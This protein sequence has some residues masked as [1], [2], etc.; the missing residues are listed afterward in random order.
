MNGYCSHD[1][2]LFC[3]LGTEGNKWDHQQSSA[4]LWGHTKTTHSPCWS[5]SAVLH[6]HLFKRLFLLTILRKPVGSVIEFSLLF[7]SSNCWSMISPASLSVSLLAQALQREQQGEGVTG[8]GKHNSIVINAQ[9]VWEKLDFRQPQPFL[10]S[11]CPWITHNTR[12]T[13][14]KSPHPAMGNDFWSCRTV[15]KSWGLQ[16]TSTLALELPKNM[17]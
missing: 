2:L 5:P 1:G 12:N 6:S 4:A 13:G 3:M 9:L 10:K 14:C 11:N 16:E 7:I 17:R 15:Q 8:A